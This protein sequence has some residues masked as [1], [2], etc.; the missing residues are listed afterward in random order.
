M[1]K[2]ARKDILL[3][4]GPLAH[5]YEHYS[6][7]ENLRL[8]VMKILW[9][10]LTIWRSQE[11][12]KEAR[13]DILLAT[14]P[15]A[16]RYVY[17]SCTWTQMNCKKFVIKKCVNNYKYFPPFNTSNNIQM[18]KL[19]IQ[20]SRYFNVHQ[21]D[22]DKVWGLHSG[23]NRTHGFLGYCMSCSVVWWLDISILEDHATFT[24]NPEDGGGRDCHNVGI[25][26]THYMAQQPRKW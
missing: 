12:H 24:F 21:E 1:H 2:E 14:G 3:S 13:K 8:Y 5:R 9:P 22:N 16:Q 15:L 17:R 7:E 26:L 10:R 20:W 23:E 18:F 6:H 25:Q 19:L 4:T 11:M